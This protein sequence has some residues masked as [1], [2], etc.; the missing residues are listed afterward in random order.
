MTHI[1]SFHECHVLLNISRKSTTSPQIIQFMLIP[2]IF[3][4]CLPYP[5]PIFSI[6]FNTLLHA[7]VCFN[8][9]LFL[10]EPLF[11]GEFGFQVLC[12]LMDLQ[13]TFEAAIFLNL[14]GCFST[15]ISATFFSV[16]F[17]GGGQNQQ[18]QQKKKSYD[19]IAAI[20][21]LAC[22]FSNQGF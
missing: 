6:F 12:L 10:N 18:G 14:G 19:D 2:I 13:P 21:N 3:K 9:C 16:G 17:G 1:I 4:R 8:P 5:Y 15:E 20:A 22:V 11:F 7:E